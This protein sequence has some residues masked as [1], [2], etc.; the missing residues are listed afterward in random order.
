MNMLLDQI[1][2]TLLSMIQISKNM[3]AKHPE[4]DF[5]LALKNPFSWKISKKLIWKELY[6]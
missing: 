2:I 1:K 4:Q 5:N 3:L 6:L